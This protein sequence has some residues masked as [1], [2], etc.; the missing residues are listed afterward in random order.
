M[1]QEIM[2]VYCWWMPG[3]LLHLGTTIVFLASPSNTDVTFRLICV[4]SNIS[5]SPENVTSPLGSKSPCWLLGPT[6]QPHCKLNRLKCR[7]MQKLYNMKTLDTKLVLNNRN[8][9]IF[10]KIRCDSSVK[11]TIARNTRSNHT[12]WKVQPGGS[13]G[14]LPHLPS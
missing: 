9:R 4:S 3:T 5:T 14:M 8:L 7:N 13:C 12:G 1:H 10:L 11:L 6:W 2:S